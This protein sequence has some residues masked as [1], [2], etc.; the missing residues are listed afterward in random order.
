M[1]QRIK[2]AV[3]KGEMNRKGIVDVRARRMREW[4]VSIARPTG[5]VSKIFSK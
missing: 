2:K 5:E 4:L 1:N 3:M